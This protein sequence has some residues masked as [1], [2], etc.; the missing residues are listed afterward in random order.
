MLFCK[1]KKMQQKKKSLFFL[2]R[3]MICT[4]IGMIFFIS[5]A[6]QNRIVYSEM[7]EEPEKIV[8]QPIRDGREQKGIVYYNQGVYGSLS[9]EKDSFADGDLEILAIPQ[10]D[11]ARRSTRG[12]EC[13]EKKGNYLIPRWERE[14][15]EK[16]DKI[17]FCFEE[18]GK[19]KFQIKGQDIEYFSE[20]FVIDTKEPVLKVSYGD[21]SGIH[22]MC[23]SP[24]N[25]NNSIQK[26]IKKISS[27]ECEV[28]TNKTG[29]ITTE[30]SEDY[31]IPETVKLKIYQIHYETN[32][33]EDISSQFTSEKWKWEKTDNT[34]KFTL[35]FE[36]EGHYRIQV[37]YKDMAGWTI[38]GKTQ[39]EKCCIEENRYVGPLY[40]IDDTKP[41]MDQIFYTEKPEKKYS[42]RSYYTNKPVMI[43]KIIEENFN[44]A[45]F[46]LQDNM[47]Y[48][49]GTT[50]MPPFNAD[51]YALRW[52]SRYEDG[53]RVNEAVLTV[54]EQAN[55]DFVMEARDGS[56]NI[57]AAIE[58]AVTYD[59]TAPV[60]EYR[61]DRPQEGD[62]LFNLKNMCF[63]PYHSYRY[64]TK[65]KIRLTITARDE[66]SGVRG[67]QC[68]FT[69]EKGNRLWNIP[70]RVVNQKN[71]VKSEELYEFQAEF[72]VDASNFKGNFHVLAEDYGGM[73]C[74]EI[75]GKGII[76]E[77]E[78]FHDEV[79]GIMLS[80]PEADH[81]DEKRKIKYFNQSLSINVSV[82]DKFSGIREWKVLAGERD[83]GKQK[84]KKYIRADYSKR[85]DVVY[86]AEK[87]MNLED[88]KCRESCP[89]NPVELEVI[90]TDNAG[91][92]SRERY[93]EYKIV[94]DCQNPEISVEYDDY[95][96]RNEKYYNRTRTATVTV[97]E[98]NFDPSAVEWQI[99][100][101]NQK[102]RIGKWT[103]E[104]E[105]HRCNVVFDQ[106]G[107]DYK[108]KLAVTDYAGNRT[109]WNED[110]EFTIDKTA[111]QVNLKMNWKD[112]KNEK[113]FSSVKNVFLTVE[114]R[115]IEK[116][117]VKIK[118]TG[119]RDGENLIIKKCIDQTE[120]MTEHLRYDAKISFLKDGDYAITVQCR[121][122]AGNPAQ[123]VRIPRFTIDRTRP[124]IK[125]QGIENGMSYSGTITPEIRCSDRNFNNGTFF[126]EIQR[127]DGMKLHQSK[128]WKLLDTKKLLKTEK[129][130]G[131]QLRWNN[132][133]NERWVDG[134]Y[135]LK[136][137][138]E[139]YAGNRAKKEIMFFVN[140]FGS[141]YSFEQHT[142]ELLKKEYLNREEDI[143]LRELNVNDTDLHIS[144]WK[145]N[146]ERKDLSGG[147]ERGIARDYL[148]RKLDTSS[149]S[150]GKR[151]WYEKEYRILKKNFTEE[152]IYQITLYS[153]GF[154]YKDG[155]KKEIKE[156]ANDLQNQ[157]IC[158]TVDKTPPV[159]EISGLDE[160]FY[161]EKQHTMVVT[162]LDNYALD[163]VEVK[164]H[165]DYGNQEDKVYQFTAAD[166]AESHSKEIILDEYSGR[167][168]ISYKAW[169]RAGNG[170]DSN[171]SGKTRSCI[172][173]RNKMV[174]TGY[175][176]PVLLG[177]FGIVFL[178]LSGGMILFFIVWKKKKWKKKTPGIFDGKQEV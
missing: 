59:C 85:E 124:D 174:E 88:K 177:I 140:R 120:K 9:V 91:Y 114:D 13:E 80:I 121:D 29:S 94:V 99:S 149:A 4:G 90:L 134:I 117:N 161:T 63:L 21:V 160:K 68:Y 42:G 130:S 157:P 101:S 89:D 30:I 105:V 52:T 141:I 165:Y 40:T 56:G 145:D 143:V 142:E 31:F 154:V 127:M 111:P 153:S 115:N 152:G 122:L 33:E 164:I 118:I 146:Q 107:E 2:K 24:Q 6:L 58:E 26:N 158:F 35:N 126:T 46:Y 151:G 92:I 11:L 175:K 76:S 136:I 78:E 25:V 169:D 131:I 132:F 113:Y 8:L 93:E 129:S 103:K 97:R 104:G 173:T 148:I 110:Q 84:E 44:R 133:P 156:T 75:H 150:N 138:A 159:V 82:W 135:C 47:F 96:A 34:Y 43:I 20:E 171:L 12:S 168:I 116:N 45:D 18:N 108:V 3:L 48:A 7:K 74:K 83:D 86:S 162:V 81:I 27:S 14:E 5:W 65:E 147:T 170:V 106:D 50:I 19:W 137:A 163:M 54:K 67:I 60:I 176:H 71:D 36:K 79:S 155:K 167:Q 100:G 10:D 123:K 144:V 178:I 128:G 102:Y 69:D 112:V 166:F 172:V 15:N 41:E 53:K 49:D 66:I 98:W 57:A 87:T 39:E 64:F 72:T 37:S 1:K 38:Q 61:P 70:D 109:V 55:H 73:I 95:H 23:E 62:I 32:S 28:Y 22:E 17:Y 16:K 51:D 125:I 119:K 139:D 77:S